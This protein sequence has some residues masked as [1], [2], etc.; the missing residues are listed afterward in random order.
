MSMGGSGAVRETSFIATKL[1]VHGVMGE[2]SSK[3]GKIASR[4]RRIAG[5]LGEAP[6]RTNRNSMR[7]KCSLT[8]Q[9]APAVCPGVQARLFPP[10]TGGVYG[11]PVSG[12][13]RR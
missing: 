10:Y 7:S 6:I 4:R 1:P 3:I 13:N 9:P 12:G 5:F 11:P 2:K 8:E